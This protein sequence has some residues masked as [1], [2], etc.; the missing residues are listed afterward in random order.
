MAAITVI[1]TAYNLERYIGGCLKELED[2]TF[3]DFEVLIVNDA[4][5]DGT[6]EIIR[7]YMGNTSFPLR[8]ITPPQHLGNPAKA[9]NF[10]LDSAWICSKYVIFLDG[11][12]SMEKDFLACL[13]AQAE[14]SG[15]ELSL[16]AYERFEEDSGRV[17]CR[18]MTGF[19]GVLELSPE[20]DR[21]AFINGSLWNKL[22]LFERIA[23]LRVPDLRVG[24]DVCFSLAL[25]ARCRRIACTDRILIRYRVRSGSAITC[26]REEDFR[27]FAEEL[28]RLFHESDPEWYRDTIGV[29]AL[30]HIG[31][32]MPFHVYNNP[33]VDI[34]RLLDWVR[35]YFAKQFAWFR[36]NRFVTPRRLFR[37]G[38]RG[39]ALWGALACHR[40]HCFS[41]FIG[42]YDLMRRV[43]KI[44]VKF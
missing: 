36:G 34:H 5:S 13:F 24:E 22:I 29:A 41:L 23:D 25:Y 20:E 26:T 42:M 10:A 12:D 40:L 6:V 16:C 27:L 7:S 28:V 17:L 37:H 19:P 43:L 44:D 32:S 18:E 30:I 15:A 11:D 39:A 14:E 21:L 9:R 8:L 33:D 3:R 4:S 1:I 35:E 2:Q 31:V 38:I